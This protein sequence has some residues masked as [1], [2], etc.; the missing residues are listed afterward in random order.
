MQVEL[1]VLSGY[2]AVPSCCI[3][4][5]WYTWYLTDKE[6][7]MNVQQH[8]SLHGLTRR[9]LGTLPAVLLPVF[10]LASISAMGMIVS[11]D[12]CISLERSLTGKRH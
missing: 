7:S 2:L 8:D 1:S 11:P 4:S 9:A 10:H 12:P 6:M 5:S 3:I